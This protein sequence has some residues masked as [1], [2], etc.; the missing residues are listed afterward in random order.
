MLAGL[1]RIFTGYGFDPEL[2]VAP[3]LEAAGTAG[4]DEELV[5]RARDTGHTLRKKISA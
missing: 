2:L 3:G 4:R 5:L 1:E